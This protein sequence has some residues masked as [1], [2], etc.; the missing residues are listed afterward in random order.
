MSLLYSAVISL[1]LYRLISFRKI[2]KWSCAVS[3][4]DAYFFRLGLGAGAV[5]IGA[6][7]CGRALETGEA[8]TMG[9]GVGKAATLTAGLRVGRAGDETSE[10]TLSLSSS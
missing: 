9:F 7:T 2:K 10:S 5:A 3:N 6:G 8:C 1:H 4:V